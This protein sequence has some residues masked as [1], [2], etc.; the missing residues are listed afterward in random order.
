MNNSIKRQIEKIYNEVYKSVFNKTD[1]AS[2]SKGDKNQVSSKIEMLSKS[3]KFEEFSL[4]FAKELAKKG[5]RGQ[6]GLW[7]KYYEVAKKTHNIA[8]PKTW[9]EFEAKILSNAVKHNFEMIKSIPSKMK[10]ILEHKYTSVLIEEVAKGKLP[11]GSFATMLSKH[12]HKNAQ[13][14]ARTETAKLQTAILENRATS[15]GSVAYEWLSS[16]DKRTR[17]SHKAMNGVIVFWRPDSQK[18]LLDKMRGNA[19]EFPNCRCTP[20]PIVDIDDLTKNSYK[21][22]DYNQ[23]KI[24]QMTRK[25]L[26]EALQKGTL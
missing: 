11:R 16:N 2:L 5:I 8:L 23:D 7:K 22:Y 6:K 3:K 12:G 20:Q 25:Q 13:L 18:P 1:L 24:I 14:I 10:E 17:Q 21:V 9:A 26:I 19:G 15:L 4:K